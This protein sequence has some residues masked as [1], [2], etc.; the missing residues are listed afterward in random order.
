M[1]PKQIHIKD[2]KKEYFISTEDILFV[3][4]DGNYSDICLTQHTKYDTVRIQIGQLWKLIEEAVPSNKHTLARIGRSYIIAMKYLQYA[5]PKKR[6]ITLH[7]AKDEVLENVPSEAIKTML[8]LLPKEQRKEVLAAYSE[9]MRLT[10]SLEELNDEHY[11]ENGHEY[12]DLGLKSGTLWATRNVNDN[13]HCS[14]FFAWGERYENDVFDEE[15][16]IHSQGK[17]TLKPGYDTANWWWRSGWCMPTEEEW[18]ELA[19][20][21]LMNWC[22]TMDDIWGCLFTGPNG[23]HIFLPAYGFIEGQERR[24]ADK[25]FYW[26]ASNGPGHNPSAI[27][28]KEFE[29]EEGK[30]MTDA[31]IL[32]KEPYLGMSIRPVIHKES[33]TTEV[34]KTKKLLFVEPANFSEEEILMNNA[35]LAIDGWE[36]RTVKLPIDTNPAEDPLSEVVKEFCPDAIVGIKSAC[37]WVQ[38]LN[39]DMRFLVEPDCKLSDSEV[40]GDCWV[41]SEDIDDVVE[42]ANCHKVELIPPY[43]ISRWKTTRLIPIILEVLNGTYK[44]ADGEPTPYGKKLLLF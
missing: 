19:D 38:Q 8:Q 16:Y 28:L 4:A 35:H 31:S 39:D 34:G 44:D 11:M 43:D 21:C 7:A 25:G 3:K 6:T 29:D 36:T 27:K 17:I 33:L 2:G 23:N 42:Y 40:T 9:R 13:G 32:W 41:L 10:L 18:K 26:T 12:V 24:D 22:K 15:E 5:D 14:D 30:V 1:T 20:Q 37:N